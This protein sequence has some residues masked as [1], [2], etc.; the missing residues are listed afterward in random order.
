[1]GSAVGVG[2][3][4]RVCEGGEGRGDGDGGTLATSA[5]ASVMAIKIGQRKS[6]KDL[7]MC[8]LYLN[9]FAHFDG[10]SPFGLLGRQSVPCPL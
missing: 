3:G 7:G 8:L 9:L 5:Q 2:E 6:R 1:M 4:R 10:Q